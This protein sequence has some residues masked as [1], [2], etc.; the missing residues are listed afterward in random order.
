MA[1][2]FW[3]AVDLTGGSDGDVDILS[4]DDIDEGDGMLVINTGSLLSYLYAYDSSSNDVE[5]TPDVIKPDDQTGAGRW[6]LTQPYLDYVSIRDNKK[7]SLGT[8]SDFQLFFDSANAY[9]DIPNTATL[10]FRNKSNT[11]AM[12]DMIPNGAVKL[13][14]NG[15]LESE[16]ISGALHATNGLKLG[17]EDI[18]TSWK[19]VD[20]SITDSGGY[21]DASDVE[22]ALQEIAQEQLQHQLTGWEASSISNIALSSDGGTP[23]TL[24]LTY[25]G[26]CYYWSDGVRYSVS[27]SDNTQIADTSGTHIIY[28][29]GASLT[30]VANPTHTQIDTIIE[31]KAICM[32]VYW[33]TNSDTTPMLC[34]ELHGVVMSGATHHY[35]HDTQG[36]KW[37]S[38]GAISGYTVSTPTDAGISFELTDIEFYDEDIKVEI[39]SSATP[40]NQYEQALTAAHSGGLGASIPVLYH[41]A[42]DQTW[43]EQ[44]ASD[45]PYL[46]GGTPR[47]QYMDAD[48]SFALTEIGNG[49]YCNYWVMAC[50][51]WQYPVKMVPG[52][53]VYATKAD[54]IT[55]A[56]TEISELGN[57]PGPEF[58]ILYRILLHDN[59]GGSTDA[60]IIDITDYRAQT[61]QGVASGAAT[62]HGG[63]TGLG[64]DDHLQY[65]L[66]DGS[67][68]LTGAMDFGSQNLTNVNVD[69]GSIDGAT[70]GAASA[71]TI[72]GTTI[73]AS[74]DFTIGDTILT[75][76]VLTDSTGLKIE[77]VINV[78]V[79][80]TGHDV[81]FYSAT[82]GD[83]FKWD[84]ANEK[85]VITGTN[86]QNAL[87]V[88]DGNVSITDMLAVGNTQITDGV[89][90]D[91]GGLSITAVTTIADTSA[92]ASSAAPVADAQIANKKYV[93]DSIGAV[94][95]FK[96]KVDAAATEDYIG[97]AASDGVIRTDD[98]LHYTDGGNYVTL[99][100]NRVKKNMIIN[101]SMQIAQYIDRF[102]AGA[103]QVT[104]KGS[105]GGYFVHDRWRLV[106]GDSPTA[107]LTWAYDSGHTAGSGLP[108]DNAIKLTVTT[109]DA[110]DS[111]NIAADDVL[112][113]EQRIIAQDCQHLMWG[114]S[115]AE[116]VT[117]SFWAR[118][119]DLDSGASKTMCIQ[120]E[121]DDAVRSYTTEVD[122]PGDDAWYQY[123]VTIPG[124]TN[125]G[126]NIT[127]DTGQGLQV[128]FTLAA[129]SNRDAATL[130]TWEA[131][132]STSYSTVD[133]DNF[134]DAVGDILYL[135]GVQLE[136]GDKATEY[137]Y[138]TYQQE[139]EDCLSFFEKIWWVTGD[140]YYGSGIC[141]SSTEAKLYI[142]YWPKRNI[143]TISDSSDGTNNL[144]LYYDATTDNIDSVTG[145]DIGFAQCA[146]NIVCGSV[147][148]AGR[149]A[150]LKINVSGAY[151]EIDAEI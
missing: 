72:V 64:D 75:D 86:G 74:T 33:N 48:N 150:C 53:E 80:G 24:T 59:A 121:V 129:G 123:E 57:L 31:D 68:T 25:T 14:Y 36:S 130:D 12:V 110:S 137:E 28:Y 117:L 119:N 38:G 116:D 21:F 88:P 35:L 91:A 60:E 102:G 148:T 131:W 85:L 13:Y 149:A 32:I 1:W 107:R 132:A 65:L 23:P 112:A 43:V 45:V 5:S 122:L 3:G 108:H 135:T 100:V 37:D 56:P 104:G 98:S 73:D 76:G 124:D 78:G 84:A 40:A 41:D 10:F 133:Q 120:I 106:A 61:L 99:G 4:V 63:L 147:L 94:G 139:F 90:A 46:V 67:R 87:E 54:S 17:S 49:Q 96:V 70:I 103:T 140:V 142:Q 138:K 118:H 9:V 22:A 77:A 11:E 125:A 109:A 71:S 79:D 51:D 29:D 114:E 93:D 126:S 16:T 26:T 50:N 62:D 55:N 27:G 19:A 101:G 69:S 52:T 39:T 111:G 8:G 92:L 18:I 105:T 82:A 95:G 42:V 20:Q 97:T 145:D 151:I 44:A 128:R 66:T 143:P 136:V 7:V 113:I 134:V 115:G 83:Y 6:H 34:N 89:I 146:L 2:K 15:I 58:I 144:V 127:N 141:R 30:S 47:I 81:V